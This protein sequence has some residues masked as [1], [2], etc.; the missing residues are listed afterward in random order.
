[1]TALLATRRLAVSIAD[2]RICRDLNLT[3]EC[4]SRWAILGRNG[5]GKTTL[6]KSLA[7]L[8]PQDSGE[9]LLNG[10]ALGGIPRAQLARALGI[11][12]QEQAS[13]FPGTVLDA[14][15]TGRHP[16][17]GPWRWVSEDDIDRARAALAHVGLAGKD[18]RELST[19]SGGEQQRL[20]IAT[21][22]AQDPVL[23][24][25]DEPS[26]HLDLFHQIRILRLLRDLSESAGKTLIMVLHDVNL[27]ARFCDHALLLFG[28]DTVIYG[29]MAEVL[30]EANLT[31]LYG[32]PITR[33]HTGQGDIFSPV[34]D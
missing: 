14:V 32:H 3:V 24:L 12:F 28:A 2:I 19:L 5:C 15:L 23:F 13:L 11:Q 8:H 4:G 22:L 9:I 16:H 25:L 31:R 33:L 1:L 6:L 18:E 17:L 29:T 10:E 30:T 26:T 7:G 21:L 20:A 34:W 27:A